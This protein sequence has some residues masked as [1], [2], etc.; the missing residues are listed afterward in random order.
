M[1]GEVNMIPILRNSGEGGG[2]SKQIW[3]GQ[4]EDIVRGGLVEKNTLYYGIDSAER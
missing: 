1:S 3:G 4:S 2:Q